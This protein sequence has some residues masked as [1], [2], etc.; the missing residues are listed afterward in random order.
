MPEQGADGGLVGRSE[1]EC[2]ASLRDGGA[3]VV[4][5]D[6]LVPCLGAVA[7]EVVAAKTEVEKLFGIGDEADLL[8]VEVAAGWEEVGTADLKFLGLE[9]GLENKDLVEEQEESVAEETDLE[10]ELEVVDFVEEVV[11]YVEEVAVVE[12]H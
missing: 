3:M 7:V 9:P 8:E 10:A 5:E 6:L 11:D 4:E 2:M 1:M 12:E